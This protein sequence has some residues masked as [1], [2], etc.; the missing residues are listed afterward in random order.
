VSQS[1][2]IV[3]ALLGGFVLYLAAQGRLGAYTAVLWG[4]TAAP[5]PTLGSGA[6]GGSSGGLGKL[7]GDVA[8]QAF[9][10]G[11]GL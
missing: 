5:A 4:P 11:L 1:G 9:M 6:S 10:A 8:T 3:A 7:A 2:W